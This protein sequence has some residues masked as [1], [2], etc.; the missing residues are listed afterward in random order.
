MAN[1]FNFLYHLQ[2]YIILIF[3]FTSVAEFEPALPDIH[4]MVL[5][6]YSSSLSLLP[7]LKNEVDN[8]N[9]TGSF[10][11]EDFTIKTL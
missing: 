8:A 6:S 11:N 3:V 9:L 5:A 4:W 2:K 10:K 1:D 7:H